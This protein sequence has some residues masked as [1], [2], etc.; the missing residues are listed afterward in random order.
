M[1][2][3]WQRLKTVTEMNF[4]VYDMILLFKYM[5]LLFWILC[6]YFINSYHSKIMFLLKFQHLFTLPKNINQYGKFLKGFSST[7]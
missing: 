2:S 7:K 1:D 5:I 4:Q 3:I 6:T